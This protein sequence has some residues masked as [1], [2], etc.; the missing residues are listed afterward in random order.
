MRNN[1]INFLEAQKIE[2]VIIQL[3]V[4]NVPNNVYSLF[5]I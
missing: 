5:N 1:W 2:P 3:E 4:R